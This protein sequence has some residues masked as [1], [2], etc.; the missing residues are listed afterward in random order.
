MADA[1]EAPD[2]VVDEDGDD[3]RVLII[4]DAVTELPLS[5]VNVASV[6]Y[7]HDQRTFYLAVGVVPLPPG[8]ISKEMIAEGLPVRPVAN[9]V[10]VPSVMELFAKQLQESHEQYV[11][12]VE[13][14][15]SG[16]AS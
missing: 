5:F 4:W 16:D 15:E 2:A 3:G 13:E 9:L 7:H 10:M 12:L 8:G 11:K 6:Q 1:N 14:S